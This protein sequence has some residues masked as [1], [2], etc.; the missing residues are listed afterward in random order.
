MPG[1]RSEITVFSDSQSTVKFAENEGNSRHSKHIEIAFC[2]VLDVFSRGKSR[3]GYRWTI[4]MVEEGLKNPLQRVLFGSTL[5]NAWLKS[6]RSMVQI[7]QRACVWKL[8]YMYSCTQF[9]LHDWLKAKH[10]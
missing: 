1:V 4:L 8:E 3:L 7:D 5:K 9:E 2:L 10:Y 6:R